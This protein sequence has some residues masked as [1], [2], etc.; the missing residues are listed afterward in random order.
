MLKYFSFC[1]IYRL[2]T[3]DFFKYQS[4]CIQ[5]LLYI[6][7][8]NCIESAIHDQLSI[9]F[10]PLVHFSVSAELKLKLNLSH[11]V[12]AA[13]RCIAPSLKILIKCTPL[14]CTAL[15][16]TPRTALHCT[17]LHC[18]TPYSTAM[19]CTALHALQYNPNVQNHG[20]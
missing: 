3:S 18:T 7:S 4:Y 19:H 20:N 16:H 12:S 14:N 10:P 17:I 6:A 5:Y 13:V 1:F 15:Y 2:L 8:K 9:I 11:Q